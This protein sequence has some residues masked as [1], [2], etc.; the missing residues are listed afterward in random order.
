LAGIPWRSLLRLDF[1][2]AAYLRIEVM[3]Q[4]F[5]KNASA[6]MAIICIVGVITLI[7]NHAMV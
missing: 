4:K 7:I 6:L 3:E 5:E 2:T 1:L